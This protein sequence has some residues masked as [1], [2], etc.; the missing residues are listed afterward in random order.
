M[1]SFVEMVIIGLTGPVLFLCFFTAA[2]YAIKNNS[3]FIGF[4]SGAFLIGTWACVRHVGI[5][6]NTVEAPSGPRKED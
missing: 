6:V 1:R 2:D 3:I 4:F 5:Y